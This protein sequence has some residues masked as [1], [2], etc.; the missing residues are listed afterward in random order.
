MRGLGTD[1]VSVVWPTGVQQLD[2]FYSGIHMYILLSP[3]LFYVLF[4]SSFVFNRSSTL[5]S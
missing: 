4:I 3:Y 5:I 1:V 2:F